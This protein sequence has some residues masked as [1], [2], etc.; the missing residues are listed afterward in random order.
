MYFSKEWVELKLR[1]HIIEKYKEG[2][3]TEQE[4]LNQ[5]NKRAEAWA[6]SDNHVQE[7]K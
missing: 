4:A 2:T 1:L 7:V 6:Q 3:I 5:I